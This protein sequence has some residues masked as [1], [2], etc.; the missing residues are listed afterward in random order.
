MNVSRRFRFSDRWRCVFTFWALMLTVCFL[1]VPEAMAQTVTTVTLSVPAKT[2]FAE[3]KGNTTVTVS[4]QLSTMR[5]VDTVIDLTLGGTA[6]STDYTIVQL[7]DLTIVAGQLEGTADLTLSPVDDIFFEGEETV[8]I[9][10]TASGVSVAGV[11]VSLTDNEEAP[12]LRTTYNN[13]TQILYEEGQST[14]DLRLTI[15]VIGG[16]LFE[17]NVTV[18]ISQDEDRLSSLNLDTD[19]DFGTNPSPPWSLTIPAGRLSADLDIKFTVI[20]DETQRTKRIC[21]WHP[22]AKCDGCS[23]Q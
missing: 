18:L 7:P 9:E 20:D 15:S 12:T 4:A 5:A 1:S 8:R 10:G 19:L 6:K 11:D 2:T 21:K 17:E 22:I 23:R 16:A 3:G 14:D 13:N